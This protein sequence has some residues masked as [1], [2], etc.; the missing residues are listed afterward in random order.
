MVEMLPLT[1][2]SSSDCKTALASVS[3][4]RIGQ[5]DAQLTE[6]RHTGGDRTDSAG[7]ANSR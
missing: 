4:A 3:H 2:D 5:R 6:A 7:R 1:C